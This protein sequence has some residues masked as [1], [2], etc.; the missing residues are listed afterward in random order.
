VTTY[1]PALTMR[2]AR[3]RYFADN[4]FSEA[5]YDD[6]WVKLEA[7]PIP[8]WIPNSAS[9]KRAVRF[10]DLHHVLTSYPTTWVGEGEIGAWEVATGCGDHHAA[11]VL[12]LGA[13]AVALV[14]APR[15]VYRAFLRGRA[16]ENLYH[17][18]WADALLDER[19]GDLR[20][21]LNLSAPQ[22]PPTTRDRLA[23]LAWSSLALGMTFG[24]G[25]FALAG[26]AYAVSRWQS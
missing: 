22:P 16:T 9:R 11:W 21:R 17:Q 23:F 13:M 7:G 4:G 8:M 14:L 6:A 20:A 15:A 26:V 5:G 3:A 2:E 1:D 24:P 10:H 12:N 19:V 25:L 18:P